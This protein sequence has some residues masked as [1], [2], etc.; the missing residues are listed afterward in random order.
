MGGKGKGK[1]KERDQK[2]EI[3]DQKNHS[4]GSVRSQMFIANEIER[5]RLRYVRSENVPLLTE[6]IFLFSVMS[7]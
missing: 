1:V 5:N 3:R 2:S 7:L 6:L 4:Q